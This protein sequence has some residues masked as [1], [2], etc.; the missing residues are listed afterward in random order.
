MMTR[1]MRNTVLGLTLLVLFPAVKV[2]AGSHLREAMLIVHCP[3]TASVYVDGQPMTTPG[4]VRQFI[5]EMKDGPHIVRIVDSKT[6]T[7]RKCPFVLTAQQNTYV[8]QW[9]RH[10][11][12]P[13]CIDQCDL[14]EDRDY[15]KKH[16]RPHHIAETCRDSC[17]NH[18][19]RN[20][21]CSHWHGKSCPECR[22]TKA[23]RSAPRHH[24][25]AGCDEKGK[26]RHAEKQSCPVCESQKHAAVSATVRC[27]ECEEGARLQAILKEQRNAAAQRATKPTPW[28]YAWRDGSPDWLET[29]T[30]PK[31]TASVK[32]GVMHLKGGAILPLDIDKDLVKACEKTDQL[33][34]EAVIQT[35][36]INQNGPAR[37][38]SFSSNTS[39]RN[40]TLGQH[41]GQLVFRLRTS[42]RVAQQNDDIVLGPAVANR[43]M[44]VVVTYD[45][46]AGKLCAYINGKQVKNGKHRAVKGHLSNWD[47]NHR[48]IVGNEVNEAVSENRPWNG[49]VRHF[50][51]RNVAIDATKVREMFRSL[52]Y[53][54]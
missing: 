8:V 45:G 41:N 12:V 1:A 35:D 33:T 5:L 2:S 48:V 3:E 54:R 9:E 52:R 31:A 18:G 46:I 16:V 15:W 20:P 38:L 29:R 27:K 39:S 53:D 10:P 40:F 28:V 14:A 21:G 17:C 30:D 32:N 6:K 49:T 7:C 4:R 19:S 22:A 23:H 44:H 43:P 13:C 36:D 42:D 37:I 26:C 24:S 50:S 51:I 47:A 11:N 25:S 34:V